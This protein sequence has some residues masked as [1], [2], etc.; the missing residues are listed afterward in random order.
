MAGIYAR[1]AINP[2]ALP[3]FT[4]GNTGRVPSFQDR[5]GILYAGRL[6][7][8]K[9]IEDAIEVAHAL[10]EVRVRIAGEGP[11][12]EQV[13]AAA[14]ELENLEYIGMLGQAVVR[15]ELRGSRVC[16]I[17]SR[18]Q[19]PGSLACLEAMS[20][21]TPVVA[22]R[23]GGLAE[24]VQDAGSGLVVEHHPRSLT[25]A[26]SRLASDSSTWEE[27]SDR[28]LAAIRE[29]HSPETYLRSILG[30]YERLANGERG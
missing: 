29:K 10:P 3:N 13:L 12:L 27:M 8:A 17:P 9:G 19:E 14:S 18:W 16:L 7:H 26:C 20:A 11:L 28:G 21:G 1:H 23:V 24:Y 4:F 5:A 22:Y 25:N 2:V 6:T 30:I 15:Q